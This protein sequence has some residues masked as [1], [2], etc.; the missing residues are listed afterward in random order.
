M[1]NRIFHTFTIQS[2]SPVKT[3]TENNH[4][5]KCSQHMSITSQ[6]HKPMTTHI[7]T[8]SVFSN[9]AKRS[10][11]HI[12]VLKRQYQKQPGCIQN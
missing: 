4:R 3:F 6:T 11:L 12:K 9:L 1:E 7:H 2:S 8:Y 10:H 5:N